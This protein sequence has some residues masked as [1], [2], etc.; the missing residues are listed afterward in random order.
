MEM[1]Q[2]HEWAEAQKIVVSVDLVD[3]AKRQLKFL[4]AVDRNRYL[5]DGPALEHAI[6]RYNACWLPLLAEHCKTPICEDPLVV[7]LDCEWIWHCHRLNPVQYESDCEKLFGRILGNSGVL[8]ST[9]EISST[10][11]EEIWKTFYPDEPYELDLTRVASKDISHTPSENEKFTE[12]DLVS[13]V[14]RQSTFFYQVSRPHVSDERFLQEAVARFKGF[15]YM[16]KRNKERSIRRFCV[17]TY[18]ID[19]MWHS[20]QLHPVSYCKDMKAA[21]GTVL[22]HDDVDSDRTKGKK[23]DTGF[24]ATTKQFEDTFG[25]RYWKAG[26]MYRGAAPIAVTET[27]YPFKPV[28]KGLDT[29][30][31]H[32]RLIQLP[33]KKFVE[34]FLEV[35]A[36]KNLPEQFKGNFFVTFSKK[37]PDWFFGPKKR[38]NIA[39][40]SGEKQVTYF[41]CEPTGQ[42]NFELVSQPSP[43]IAIIKSGKAI[44]SGSLALQDFMDSSSKVSAEKWLELVPVNGSLD[45]KP[46][47]L[48]MAA[49]FTVPTAATRVFHLVKSRPFF[50]SSCFFP[51]PAS[52]KHARSLMHVVDQAGMD[53]V[54]IQIRDTFK[55]STKAKSATTKQVIGIMESGEE[56]ILADFVENKWSLS[57]AG[58]SFMLRKETGHGNCIFELIGNKMFKLYPGRRLDYEPRHC[59]KRRSEQ[60]FVTAVEFSVENPYGIAAALFDLRSGTFMVKEETLALPFIT[61]AAILSDVLKKEGYKSFSLKGGDPGVLDNKPEETVVVPETVEEELVVD[62]N[63]DMQPGKEDDLNLKEGNQHAGGCGAGCGGGCGHAVKTDGSRCLANS[64]GC[65]SGCG[66]DCGSMIKST[67][68]GAGCSGGCGKMVNGGACSGGCGGSCGTRVDVTNGAIC[69]A[70]QQ[71]DNIITKE[72]PL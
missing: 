9:Q 38:L 62:V 57:G 35:V 56:H 19:L 1:E 28:G 43:G 40:G 68:C 39:S 36:V 2:Q 8:S 6:Y 7:P 44:G 3:A 61:L 31:E 13:A 48:H 33:E 5:Y 63:T 45:S 4:A 25:F 66:G 53:V 16:I 18:D 29:S 60:D 54:S 72:V 32:Q 15:L 71:L 14:K 67:G 59:E 24:S 58:G 10:Q 37:D 65:G 42:L 12:Y 17:P 50:N 23:L 22:E 49:S 27:P 20:H 64:G 52:F 21:L 26:A 47:L 70:R 55:G 34:V 11:T 46:I 51:L 30:N 69:F 41:Q